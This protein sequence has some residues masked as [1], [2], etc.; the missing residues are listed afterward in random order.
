M[1][2]IG[3]S[4]QVVQRGLQSRGHTIITSCADTVTTKLR[5]VRQRGKI[6]PA[7][8]KR[9]QQPIQRAGRTRS[10]VARDAL[11]RQDSIGRMFRA[12][13]IECDEAKLGELLESGVDMDLIL[14]DVGG[15]ALHYAAVDAC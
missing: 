9:A 1:L 15:T 12:C 14:D 8:P 3:D 4:T 6:S 7:P 5:S 11:F 2:K 13:A 10:T